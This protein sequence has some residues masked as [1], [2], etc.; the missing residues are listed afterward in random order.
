MVLVLSAS[1]AQREARS[2]LRRLPS[3][4]CDKG[5]LR[6]RQQLWGSHAQHVE[7]MGEEGAYEC[8]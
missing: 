2:R 7:S 3:Q 8:V 4:A 6:L 1:K 5:F